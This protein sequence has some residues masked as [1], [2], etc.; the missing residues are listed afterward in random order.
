MTGD[1]T[2]TVTVLPS[3][4]GTTTLS[5]PINLGSDDSEEQTT[6]SVIL[7]SKDLDLVFS[8]GNQTVGLR[9]NEVTIPQGATI[10]DAYIQFATKTARS[11]VTSLTLEGEATDDADTFVN[12]INGNI[13][14]RPRTTAD[15]AWSPAPWATAGE[16]GV[17]QR[18]PNLTSIVQEIVDRAGWASSNSLAFIIT[19]T[20][21]RD[22][23][24]F[25]TTPPASPPVLHVEYQ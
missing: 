1:D 12:N 8:G 16:T 24:S 4:G 22:A 10:V 17:D 6:G 13:S 20:G 21:K 15:I 18:T 25:E 11:Q 2:I 7:G 14:S 5:I 3:G 9:F 19:G 23:Q